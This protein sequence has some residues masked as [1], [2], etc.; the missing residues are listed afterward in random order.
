[1]QSQLNPPD[2]RRYTLDV[3]MA[4]EVDA[5]FAGGNHSD[6]VLYRSQN[7]MAPEYILRAVG[8]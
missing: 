4:R 5:F 2:W 6:R 7:V 1:M 8:L 3:P